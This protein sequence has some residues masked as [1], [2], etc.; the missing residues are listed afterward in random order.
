MRILS[1][2]LALV[3]ATA[4]AGDGVPD[5]HLTLGAG[6]AATP[7]YFGSDEY[8]LGPTGSLRIGYARL[9]GLTFGRLEDGEQRGLSFGGALRFIGERSADDYPELSGLAD[10]DASLE[11]G[12]SVSY[13]ADAWRAFGELRYGVI[14]HES[15]VGTLGAD[16][17]WRP[18]D[19]LTLR[20]G[21]RVEWGSSDF[22]ATYFGVTAAE[23]GASG[24]DAFEPDSGVYSTGVEV[25]AIYDLNDN[26]E[27]VTTY[28]YNR[29]VGD[30]GDSPIVQQGTDDQ[31]GV[32]LVF[33]RAFTLDF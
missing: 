8:S 24:L 1:A 19:R 32:S 6:V 13:T 16:A 30:A 25:Q 21:P 26:W 27:M 17:I 5:L 15:L 18:S 4:M 23:A 22:N 12:G 20:A 2:V 9:G 33:R 29:L 28:S 31:Y 7:E 3:P 11:L 10:V 14:G